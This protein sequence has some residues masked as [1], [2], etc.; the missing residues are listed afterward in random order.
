MVVLEFQN[1]KVNN[2]CFCSALNNGFER[3]GEGNNI[4]KEKENKER[5]NKEKYENKEKNEYEN[6]NE[7]DNGMKIEDK[8]KGMTSSDLIIR[9]RG[10]NDG[11][12]FI[13]NSFSKN[14]T[15][16]KNIHNSQKTE[17]ITTKFGTNTII[18]NFDFSFPIHL[19]Y[20]TPHDDLFSVKNTKTVENSGFKTVVVP[21]PTI[22]LGAENC[23]KKSKIVFGTPDVKRIYDIS[24]L[25]QNGNAQ[26][27]VSS[28]NF[29]VKI[30]NLNNEIDSMLKN[31]DNLN[32]ENN[33]NNNNKNKNNAVELKVPVGFYSNNFVLFATVFCYFLTSGGIVFSLLF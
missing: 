27:M 14:V 28:D 3:E 22:Y 16:E 11:E 24:F 30:N 10:S 32:F 20:H 1:L 9:E 31:A 8:I 7:N 2:E 19:R 23:E 33:K 15:Q 13:V 29:Y 17:N 12:T 4:G 6:E 26:S 5:E 21:H 18:T 25:G